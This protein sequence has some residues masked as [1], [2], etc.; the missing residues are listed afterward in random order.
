MIIHPAKHL[1]EAK[2]P[3]L[4][5]HEEEIFFQHP[6]HN[7]KV[8]QLGVIYCDEI[9][10]AIYHKGDTSIV[11]DQKTRK[12]CGSKLRVIWE[13][14][15]GKICSSP[16]FFFANS[17]PL[18]TRRENLILCRPLTH[19]ERAPY[20]RARNRFVEASVQH[21]LK[22]EARMGKMGV[23]KDTVYQMLILPYWLKSAR[24]KYDVAPIKSTAPKSL[25]RRGGSKSRTTEA[26][27]DE[28]E[29]LFFQHLT[30]YHIIQR[31]GWRSTSRVKK[32]IKDRGLV[33]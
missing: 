9:E 8:N 19:K 7:L 31:M 11:R 5:E 29:R 22:I 4:E 1:F 25:E 27:A 32:V 13:C 23:D 14:Y 10:Y 21:L 26:E 16:H 17:N 18:D 6:V 33:R 24:K 30:Y 20:L 15:I 28:V 3:T 2:F 12:N